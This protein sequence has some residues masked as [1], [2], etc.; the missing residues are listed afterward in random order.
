MPK[1]SKTATKQVN[2]SLFELI[3]K[4]QHEM[5]FER[6]HGMTQRLTAMIRELH[7][8][9]YIV[10][11]VSSI[12]EK[13]VVKLVEHWH[14]KALSHGSIKNRLADL[15]FVCGKLKRH[16]IVKENSYYNVGPRTI[17]LKRNKAIFNADFGKISDPHLRCSLQLQQAFGLRREECLKIIPCVADQGNALWLK[18]SWTKGGIPRLIP[19]RTAMQR[20]A[21]NEA[22]QLVQ[23]NQSL[24]PAHKKYIQQ[25]RLYDS[26]TRTIGLNHLHGFRHAYAQTR[27]AE[28][29]GWEPPINGG[30]SRKQMTVQEKCLDLKA[31]LRISEELGHS[32]AGITRI[33]IG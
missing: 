19:I 16:S 10:R 25:R 2:Y 26:E 11:H 27:Y 15:R 24:I 31:R 6:K 30:K 7:E 23:A 20:Q 29:T 28:L 4:H 33:Y 17:V 22:K 32:R 13:H 14:S 1:M 12:K 5:S 8:M 21:L 9:G 18:G 3:K